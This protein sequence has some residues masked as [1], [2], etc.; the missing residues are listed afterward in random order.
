MACKPA[1]SSMSLGRAWVHD[2]QPKLEEAAA[3][4]IQGIELWY[5]DLEYSTRS[6]TGNAS[7]ASLLAAAEEVRSLCNKYSLVIIC[8][9][10]F[11]LDEGLN[12]REEHLARIAKLHLWFDLAEKLGTD[13]IAI[14]SSFLPTEYLSTD[15]ATII[16]DLQEVADLGLQRSPAIRFTYESLAWG[17]RVNTWEVCWN[18]VRCVNRPNFGICL[19]T[20]NIAGRVFA[21]PTSITGKTPTAEMDMALSVQH[22]IAEIDVS[23][24]FYIQV[25]DAEKLDEPLVEGHHFYHPDQPPRMS[26][27]RNCRLF[28]GE[29]NLGAYLPVKNILQAIIGSLEYKGW[30]SM[31]LF[32]RSMAGADPLVPSIH[33]RRAAIAW[34]KIMKDCKLN[35]TRDVRL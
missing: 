14:A 20:F 10:P 29:E 3:H 8:L 24:V 2:L 4:G 16:T 22:L 21:D 7:R 1:I 33:A 11:M 30:V 23:K 17:T 13:L 9:Q 28:Y 27:S 19:D 34:E 25:V 26:W 32:N 31:E 15:V 18:I 12:D 35:R 6:L 5:E